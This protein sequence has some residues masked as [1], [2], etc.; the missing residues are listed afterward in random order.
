MSLTQIRTR[1][2]ATN[3]QMRSFIGFDRTGGKGGPRS[4]SRLESSQSE[5][6]LDALKAFKAGGQT[7]ISALE[8][9]ELLGGSRQRFAKMV[10]SGKLRRGKEKL[11]NL[12][13]LIT[14]VAI[15]LAQ[16]QSRKRHGLD[17]SMSWMRECD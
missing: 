2:L 15:G 1:P 4:A 12:D 3:H 10:T 9:A 14:W 8:A 16:G 17:V 11:M 7:E 5:G 13:S 6:A